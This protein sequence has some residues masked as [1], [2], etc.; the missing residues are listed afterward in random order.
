MKNQ[1]KINNIAGFLSFLFLIALTLIPIKSFALSEEDTVKAVVSASAKFDESESIRYYYDE[2]DGSLTVYSIKSAE[3]EYDPDSSSLPNYS[4]MYIDDCIKVKTD[5]NGV[6]KYVSDGIV[7]PAL[8]SDA[9][10][11]LIGIRLWLF[12]VDLYDNTSILDFSK[13][14][15]VDSDYYI[16]W[17]PLL[18]E[19]STRVK[20]TDYLRTVFSDNIA[21]AYIDNTSLK[22]YGN[23]LYDIGGKVA[24]F[25]FDSENFGVQEV[26]TS[27]NGLWHLYRVTVD[28]DN[29]MQDLEDV[30][31]VFYVGILY[32]ENGWRIAQTTFKDENELLYLKEYNNDNDEKAVS[33]PSTDDSATLLPVLL[34]ISLFGTF[35]CIRKIKN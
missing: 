2:E 4:F 22:I 29:D 24:Q 23:E 18:D 15:I 27:E 6:L 31:D 35:F 10:R 33:N 1:S 12:K 21:L 7:P 11:A 5:E 13:T 8:S 30:Y 9:A 14:P 3:I 17:Y 16:E 25:S 28:F 26:F 19:F 34:C 20:F 32:T